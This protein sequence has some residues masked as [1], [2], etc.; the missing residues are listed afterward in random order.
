[1]PL[2]D[3]IVGIAQIVV[4]LF[5]IIIGV[6]TTFRY[7]SVLT[8]KLIVGGFFCSLMDVC[9]WLPYYY[10]M[11]DYPY[12]ISAAVFSFIGYYCFFLSAN[13]SLVKYWSEEQK[14]AAGKYRLIASIAPLIT[15]LFCLSY[16]FQPWEAENKVTTIRIIENSMLLVSLS[17]WGYV[18]LQFFLTMRKT[19]MSFF[20][21][22]VLLQIV[23]EL[24]IFLFSMFPGPLYYI[25]AFFQ[26]AGWVFILPLAKKAVLT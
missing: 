25:F 17:I 15:L 22:L 10:I 21:A 24:L 20:Y 7:R 18:T 26:I 13:F 6:R 8:Y 16:L 1:M 14:Q 11:S 4:L 2:A 9:F 5:L 19:P 12:G 23:L 3:L